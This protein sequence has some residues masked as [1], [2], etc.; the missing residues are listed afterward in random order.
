MVSLKRAFGAFVLAV[1]FSA[2]TMAAPV[3]IDDF[4]NP[5]G[6]STVIRNTNGTSVQSKTGAGI[7]GNSR[8]YSVT[9]TVGT[10]EAG[11]L[12]TTGSKHVF[13]VDNNSNTGRGLGRLHYDGNANGTFSNTGLNVD[14]TGGGTNTNF[15]FSDFIIN[16]SNGN[17][18]AQTMTTTVRDTLG[19]SFSYVELL[20]A[21]DGVHIINFSVFT[22]VDF[23]KVASLDFK[24]DNRNGAGI[25]GSDVEFSFLKATSGTPEPG[26]LVLALTGAAGLAFIARRKKS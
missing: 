20:K 24:F 14:L 7:L 1:G 26:T 8:E 10:I 13:T 23:T 5:N 22:G 17:L 9:R 6:G 11:T 16:A 2:T 12:N 3:L 18:T 19:N 25:A 4:N 15:L 21:Q